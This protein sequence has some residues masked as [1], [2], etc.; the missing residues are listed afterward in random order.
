MHGF[1]PTLQDAGKL[2]AGVLCDEADQQRSAEES[3][4]MW[5]APEGSLGQMITG[6]PDPNDNTAGVW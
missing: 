6:T 4:K 2:A 3:S 1:T 5:S